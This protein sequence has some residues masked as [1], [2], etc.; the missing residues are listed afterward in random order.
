MDIMEKT[1]AQKKS[2]FY[3]NKNYEKLK[4]KRKETYICEVCNRVNLKMNRARHQKSRHHLSMLGNKLDPTII[5]KRP[6]PKKNIQ[7]R[8]EYNIVFD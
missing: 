7:E 2:Q 8:S 3:Y 5:K 1:D 6:K 4:I